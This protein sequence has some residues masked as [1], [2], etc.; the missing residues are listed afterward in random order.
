MVFRSRGNSVKTLERKRVLRRFQKQTGLHFK[1]VSLLNQ[2]LTHRSFVHEQSHEV[3]NNERLEFLGDSVLGLVIAEYLFDRMSGRAEGE[4][5]RVKSTVVSE[6]TLSHVALHIKIDTV[7]L[8]SKGEDRSGGKYK[9]SILSD[10]FEA[11]LGA[12][13][14]DSG[15]KAVRRFLLRYFKPEI[16]KVLDGRSVKDYKTL[17]QELVQKKFKVYPR[18]C[19]L[20]KTGP[21]HSKTFEIMVNVAGR[22]FGPGSGKS[23]KQAERIAAEYAYCSLIKEMGPLIDRH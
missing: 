5:A 22:E 13:F 2:S 9:S 20:K 14:I 16:E 19:L 18:Y 10:S 15:F 3:W 17:L 23:K 6:E 1:D 8:L 12:Y 4:L 11:V 21:E 7:L